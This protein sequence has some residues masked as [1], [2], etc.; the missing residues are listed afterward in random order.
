MQPKLYNIVRKHNGDLT[1]FRKNL[2]LKQAEGELRHWKRMAR[3]QHSKVFFEMV[4][5]PYELTPEGIEK[6]RIAE[7]KRALAEFLNADLAKRNTCLDSSHELDSDEWCAAC[8]LFP[9]LDSY[10]RS[11]T[12]AAA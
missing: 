8:G 1:I 4:E 5:V 7:E 2:P 9:H 10:G 3:N 12:T 11:R 6:A